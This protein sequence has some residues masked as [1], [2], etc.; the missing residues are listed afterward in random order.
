MGSGWALSTETS[1]TPTIIFTSAS[2]YR[3][4]FVLSVFRERFGG[5]DLISDQVERTQYPVALFIVYVICVEVK[6]INWV[7]VHYYFIDAF[8]FEFGWRLQLGAYY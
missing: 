1:I 7:F 5:L 4:Y 2:W 6:V 3:L 8:K